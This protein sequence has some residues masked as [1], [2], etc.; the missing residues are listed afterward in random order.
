MLCMSFRI[1]CAWGDF[2]GRPNTDYNQ[3]RVA[4]LSPHLEFRALR[5]SSKMVSFWC[6]PLME[7][8][9]HKVQVATN[10]FNGKTFNTN[11]NAKNELLQL[12]L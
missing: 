10:R 11:K 6:N 3:L 12:R 2:P 5:I 8:K 7:W 1:A 9:T 4:F